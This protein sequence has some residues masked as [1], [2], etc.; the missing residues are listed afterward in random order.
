MTDSIAQDAALAK[1]D[2]LAAQ[3][4]VPLKTWIDAL[5]S[6]LASG[7]DRETADAR[8]CAVQDLLAKQENVEDGIQFLQWRI[9]R[10]PAGRDSAYWRSAAETAARAA[11]GLSA[12]VQEAGFGQRIAPRECIRRFCL[13]RALRKGAMCL[14]RTWGFGIVQRAD[15]ATRRI[16][17]NF[18]SRPGHV[19]PMKAAAETLE[20][21]P[22]DHLLARFF[23]DPDATRALVQDAPGE[24]VKLALSSFGPLPAAELQD[25]LV[26]AGILA[27]DDWKRFWDAARRKLK[28]DPTV[29]L[30]AKRVDPIRLLDSTSGYDE[31]WFARLA[32]E[33]D[34][35]EILA[36]LREIAA[37]GPVVRAA[38]RP[39]QITTLANR[40]A[41][42]LLGASSKQPGLRLQGAMLAAQLQ[43]PTDTCDWPRVAADLMPGAAIV[44]ALHDLPARDIRPALDFLYAR[45]PDATHRALIANLP[46]F[47]APVFAEIARLLQ[48]HKNTDALRDALLAACAARNVPVEWLLWIVRNGAKVPAWNL[49]APPALA[50]IIVDQLERDCMGERLKAQKQLHARFES[51]DWLK[52]TF[53]P[54]PPAQRA[55][56]FRRINRS[57]AWSGLDRQVLQANILKLYPELQAT[58]E[59][60]DVSAPAAP[61][62]AVT[63]QR[64]YR[65]RQAQLDKIDN[66]DIPENAREIALARS[67][68][69]LSENYEYKAAKDMQAVLHARRADLERQLAS[70]RPTD[71]ADARA[72]VAGPGTRVSIAYP[73]GR[74]ASFTILGEWDQY[75]ERQ[76]IASATRLAQALTGKAPGETA[77]VPDE[78]GRD[79]PC[80]I[81]SVLPLD[82]E[83]KEWVK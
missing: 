16:E 18:R 24:I 57:P 19:L 56:F 70:V 1:L 10:A 75:P 64:S 51:A 60:N 15:P 59:E 25:R 61:A 34:L 5:E 44:A 47:H 17:V 66:V 72:D 35:G 80:T 27:A 45:D 26:R 39:D 20:L 43:L 62:L 3:A 38:A 76:V 33:R 65:E 50:G 37:A 71:F 55:E 14:H 12:L 52:A 22:E 46:A 73:D 21:L 23:K 74:T 9:A 6:W 4:S 58:L 81:A 7:P 82:D 31:S 83:T 63:S 49:P 2:E 79:V 28:A 53:A 13:L 77:L 42:L 36:R 68:G 69:D 78:S 30:P 40:V 8:I 32:T 54:W 67:Y 41:F 29:E 48:D 11:P